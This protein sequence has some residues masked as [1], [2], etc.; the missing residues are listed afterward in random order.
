MEKRPFDREGTW[1]YIR[2]EW[3][4][5]KVGTKWECIRCSDCCRKDWSINLTW[6][7]YDR[8]RSDPRVG[9]L[10]GLGLESDPVSGLDHPFFR[11]GGRCPMFKEEGAV[12]TIHPDWPYTCAVYPFLLLPDG[13][14][15]AHEDCRGF[16]HGEKVDPA[17][18]VARIKRERAR[19][20][21]AS[22][23]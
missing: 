5:V 16:G 14:L 22:D 9:E 10:P 18:W 13:R 21:M 20:G 19:A 1:D 6:K 23:R 11:T 12:C 17:V 8:L 15:M 7:E 3:S 4:E 2:S